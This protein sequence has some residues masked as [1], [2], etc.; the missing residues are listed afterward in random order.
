M[1]AA[2][3]KLKASFYTLTVLQL[4]DYNIPALKQQLHEWVQKTPLFF[5]GLPIIIDLQQLQTLPTLN[6]SEIINC[7]RAHGFMPVGVQGGSIEQQANAKKLQ[8][9]IFPLHAKDKTPLPEIPQTTSRTAKVIKNHVRSGQRIYAKGDLIVLGSVSPGAELL[10]EG[11]I[12]IYGKLSGKALAGVSD[13]K[14]AYIFC[15]KIEA[16]LV[17]IAGHYW[18]HEDLQQNP[19]QTNVYIS[20]S[21]EQLHIQAVKN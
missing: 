17:A 11:H 8:L 19:L 18:L 7:L 4:Q 20:L 14:H 10:A 6:L 16:E 13:N 9:S 21:N 15:N 2:S 12:H 1:T 3:F 5:Q